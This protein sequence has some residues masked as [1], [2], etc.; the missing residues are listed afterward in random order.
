MRINNYLF[1]SFA[2][3]FFP[4][5]LVLFFIASVVIF[6]R[7]AGVT[8]VVKI[9]FFELVMLYFYT[10][11]TMLFFVVPLSF[12][13]ACVLGLSRLSFDYELPVLFALGMRPFKIIS[14]FLPIAFLTSFSL[15]IISLVLIPLSDVAYKSF[16]QER[17]NSININLQ[18]GE[19][20]QKFGDFLVY[21][22]KDNELLNIYENIV[23]LSLDKK[24]GGLVFAS[25]AKLFN[26]DG[27]IEASLSNGKMYRK[28]EADIEKVDFSNLI[29]RN[30]VSLGSDENL[31][32]LDYWRRAFYDS[33]N[34]RRTKTLK[35]LSMSALLS[36]FPLISIF[37]YPLLGV[38]NPRYQKNYTIL[39]TMFAV[40]IYMGCLYLCASYAPLVGIPL[41]VLMWGGCGYFL[42][43]QKVAKFY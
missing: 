9:S 26:K 6:I 22:Q 31:G 42:Y 10:L 16:L 8:F 1:Q 3:V 39:Q 41:L 11:P 19:F 30:A 36:L 34:Y 17:Q 23:L 43:K 20:G 38:K 5:F 12:F 24:N 33:N 40:S 35:N 4:I 18:A 14:T 27:I 32:V 2:Q 15:F 21:V 13:V 29:L 7:I 28:K 25:D 37:Y